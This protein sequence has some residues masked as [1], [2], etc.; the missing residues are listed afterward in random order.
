MTNKNT[1]QNSDTLS[2]YK[3]QSEISRLEDFLSQRIWLQ[4]LSQ[5]NDPFEG[6]LT[7]SSDP[8]NVQ[9]GTPIFEHHLA[10]YKK[11]IDPNIT[12]DEFLNK[13][14][15]PPFIKLLAEESKKLNWDVFANHGAFCF[16]SSP[17]DIPMWGYYAKDHRGFCI[18]FEFDFAL[19]LSELPQ[20][21]EHSQAY[22][23]QVLNGKQ[24]I[25]FHSKYDDQ[26][27]FVFVKVQYLPEPPNI[28]LDQFLS[29]TD[30]YEAVHYV[31]RNSIGVKFNKLSHE[32]E[33]RLIANANSASSDGQLVDLKKYAPFIK[34]TGV[35]MGA[36]MSEEDK[37]LCRSL[38]NKYKIKLSQAKCSPLK[39]E[40]LI[41]PI[42]DFSST[43]SPS[44]NIVSIEN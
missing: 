10:Y 24:I 23:N 35:I 13:L 28:N 34:V 22:K 17:S 14:K 18:T 30:K 5:F 21:R 27:K 43:N 44:E 4:P 20:L 36:R 31:I 41:E 8:T 7:V 38:C 42:E 9:M 29:I 26:V 11:L 25:S 15:S 12:P 2:L 32:G 16:A 3:Y 6:V 37:E 19:I 39:Y 40:V 1:A 33:Y